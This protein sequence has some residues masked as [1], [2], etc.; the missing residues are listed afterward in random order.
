MKLENISL[1]TNLP[2]GKYRN[3]LDE[4]LDKV[5]KKIHYLLNKLGFFEPDVND[6]E[7]INMRHYY[8]AKRRFKQKYDLYHAEIAA[9]RIEL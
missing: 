8:A 9:G 1:D 2:K 7:P 6:Y 5:D 3:D 4:E